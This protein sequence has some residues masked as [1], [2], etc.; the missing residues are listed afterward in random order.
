MPNC[1]FEAL[2]VVPAGGWEFDLEE[3]VPFVNYTITIPAGD[4]YIS[5]LIAEIEDQMNDSG[6]AGA[7]DAYH[8]TIDDNS[9]TSTGKVTISIDASVIDSFE[10]TWTD[11][12]LR[13]VLG[14]TGA[15]TG[16]I[17]GPGATSVTGDDHALAL[18]LP[19]CHISGQ[20][21]PD[22][23]AGVY[24]HDGTM[25]VAP[26]GT[27][28]ALSY[29]SR[30]ENF[31]RLAFLKG[32]KTWTSLERIDNESF[33]TLWVGYLRR[34]VPFRYYRDRSVDAAYATY[35]SPSLMRGYAPRLVVEDLVGEEAGRVLEFDVIEYTE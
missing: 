5:E 10:I 15:S 23:D 2:I 12:D 7:S 31:I 4:Y 9:D 16:A 1:K 33:E 21:V 18:H 35:L 28:C 32:Y 19:N 26:D 34:G 8:V 14:F 6:G 11:T 22:G 27:A 3:G 24:I 13:D 29:S 20:L 30:R 25:T 17:T